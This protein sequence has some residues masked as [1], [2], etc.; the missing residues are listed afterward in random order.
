MNH[1]FTLNESDYSQFMNWSRSKG[2]FDNYDFTTEASVNTETVWHD[3]PVIEAMN[4]GAILL[5]DEIDLASNKIMCLQSVLEGNGVFLKK[6]NRHVRPQPGFNIFATANTKGRGSDDGRFIGTN[7]LNEAFLERFAVTFEQDY[8]SQSVEAKILMKNLESYGEIANRDSAEQLVTDL[9]TWSKLIRDSFNTG[10]VDDVISTRRLINIIKAYVIWGKIN[11]AIDLCVARFDADT[12][13]AFR[14]YFDKIYRDPASQRNTATATAS[15]MVYSMVFLNTVNLNA[16]E[17]VINGN[18][19]KLKRSF[20]FTLSPQ[21]FH[22]W[23]GVF[24]TPAGSSIQ[25]DTLQYLLD[26]KSAKLSA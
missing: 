22:Y 18:I 26:I 14:E 1:T 7:I 4:R 19:S 9:T 8:P 21:G 5:L 11:K 17:E 6:V 23:N 24:S 16:L 10:A 20:E 3:G 13:K 15:H 2:Y 25:T 12:S